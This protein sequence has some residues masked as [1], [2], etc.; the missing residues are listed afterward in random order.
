MVVVLVSNARCLGSNPGGGT[1]NQN[2]ILP[3]LYKD[4][5]TFTMKSKIKK[6]KCDITKSHKYETIV[7]YHNRGVELMKCDICGKKKEIPLKK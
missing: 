4:Y 7:R 6:I 1:N 5:I 3:S 2:K